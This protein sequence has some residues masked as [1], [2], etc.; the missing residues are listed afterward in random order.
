MLGT[1]GAVY[2]IGMVLLTWIV[3]VPAVPASGQT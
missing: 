1:R 2:R 3:L